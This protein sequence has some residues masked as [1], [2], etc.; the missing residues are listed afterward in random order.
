MSDPLEYVAIN[1][2]SEI[3]LLC[4]DEFQVTDIGD[5]LILKKLF[6]TLFNYSVVLVTTSNR[7]PDDLYKGGH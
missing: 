1:L 7:Y 2:A 5:A 3:R 6:E 4:L